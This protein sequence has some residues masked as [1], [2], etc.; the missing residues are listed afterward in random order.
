MLR[1]NICDYNDAYILVRGDT[2]I[3]GHNFTQTAFRNFASFC[4]FITK[5]DR[6]TI[7]DAEDLDLV[8]RMYNLLESKSNYSD[9]TGNLYFILKMKQLILIL[10]LLMVML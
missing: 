4:K 8:M 5:T 6:T 1:S 2:T 9:T 10:I 7:V 3:L